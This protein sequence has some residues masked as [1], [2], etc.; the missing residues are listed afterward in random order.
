MTKSYY[1]NYLQLL[2][3]K[4]R[5]IYNESYICTS[6]MYSKRLSFIVSRLYCTP[7]EYHLFTVSLFGTT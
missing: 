7:S 6:S 4:G 3:A 2:Y 1:A 5:E